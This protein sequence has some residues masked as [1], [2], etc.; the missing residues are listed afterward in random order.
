MTVTSLAKSR[1]QSGVPSEIAS[2][3]AELARQL[4]QS[5]ALVSAARQ[6]L[7]NGNKYTVDE[8]LDMAEDLTGDIVCLQRI[9]SYLGV[10]TARTYA[11]DEKEGAR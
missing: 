9:G 1:P 4:A 10:D 7:A 8:L 6:S 3:L 2:A 5:Y 11:F